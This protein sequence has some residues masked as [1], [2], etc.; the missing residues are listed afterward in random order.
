[1]PNIKIQPPLIHH[2]S[3]YLFILQPSVSV[4]NVGQLTCDLII[5]TLQMKKVGYFCPKCFLPV[6]G[7]NPFYSSNADKNCLS[8]NNEGK[9]YLILSLLQFLS[10]RSI[11]YNC[12]FI[13]LQCD[14]RLIRASWVP[15]H[16]KSKSL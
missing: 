13:Y 9:V 14:A 5:N 12:M 4:G 3:I 10:W 8:L 1:M 16:I 2:L 11:Y 15:L 7:N 6:V